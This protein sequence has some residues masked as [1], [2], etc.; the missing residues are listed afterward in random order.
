MYSKKKWISLLF[1]IPPF[2]LIVLYA[3]SSIS[4]DDEVKWPCCLPIQY[5][6]MNA[7]TLWCSV[8]FRVVFGFT[9]QE[10]KFSNL[11]AKTGERTWCEL[12]T[13]AYALPLWIRK[14][15]AETYGS[16]LNFQFV[17]GR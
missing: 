1:A 6:V 7:W 16:L 14:K 10:S 3:S 12:H 8:G 11:L 17:Q 5:T 9:C 2:S 15:E 4:I 13:F